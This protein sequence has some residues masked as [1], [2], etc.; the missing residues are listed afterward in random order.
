M[1]QLPDDCISEIVS[2]TSPVDAAV[3]SAISKRFK[4]SSE[5]DSF[6]LDKKTGNKC[7]TVAPEDLTFAGLNDLIRFISV[8]KEVSRFA[9][10]AA[11][12]YTCQKICLT[13]AEESVVD[14]CPR[15]HTMRLIWCKEQCRYRYIT[16]I[17]FL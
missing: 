8:A 17:L 7:F 1:E 11:L 10:I 15:K 3:F 9:E 16:V 6:S 12:F 5:S 14:Y 4:A 2:F 13:F